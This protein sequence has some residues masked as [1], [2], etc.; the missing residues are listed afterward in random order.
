MIWSDEQKTAIFGRGKN[1][2]VSAAAG[3][4]KTAV[5][6]ERCMRRL[7]RPE[8]PDSLDDLVIVTF[9]NA[10]ASEMRS[11]ISAAVGDALAADPGSCHLRR[12]LDRVQTARIMTIHAFCA[13]LI[14]ENFHLLGV[15]PEFRVVSGEEEDEL[16]R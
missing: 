6:V 11:R 2:L 8:A 15:N 7:T 1:V 5:L 10:A 13:R 14:R 9:T 12:E 16:R 3:S 4:G